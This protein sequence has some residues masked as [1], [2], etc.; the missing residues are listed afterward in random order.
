MNS[1]ADFRFTNYLPSV[2]AT[3][4]MLHVINTVEPCL[5]VDYHNQILATLG[6]DKV[7]YLSYFTDCLR[8]CSIFLVRL[9][10]RI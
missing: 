5:A 1:I 3:A 9:F 7:G 2:L 8:N 10:N 4:I 6:V